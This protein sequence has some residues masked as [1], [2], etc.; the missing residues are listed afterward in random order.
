MGNADKSYFYSSCCKAWLKSKWLLLLWG[1][2]LL[3]NSLQTPSCGRLSWISKHWSQGGWKD[4]RRGA[5]TPL[6]STKQHRP[7][8]AA[9][10]VTT[11]KHQTGKHM[12]EAPCADYVGQITSYG[13]PDMQREA[14]MTWY[15]KQT[16]LKKQSYLIVTLFHTKTIFFFSFAKAIS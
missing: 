4:L 7:C 15:R 16:F 10:H 6:F 13:G 9:F 11:W 2:P 3:K 8:M 5:R 14:D 1:R 12:H